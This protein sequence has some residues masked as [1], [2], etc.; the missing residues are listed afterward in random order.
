S[1]SH[2]WSRNGAHADREGIPAAMDVASFPWLVT[3]LRGFES[4]HIHR[5]A[6]L[7]ADAAH[8]R[9]FFASRD[10][11][12]LIIVP[13][14]YGNTLRGFL[15]VEQVRITKT[16]LEEDITM[17]KFLGE[18]F[19]NALERKRAE[20]EL[21]VSEELFRS[22][23]ESIPLPV[24]ITHLESGRI[25][26][27]NG[28]VTPFFGGSAGT[29]LAMSIDDLY[30]DRRDR[31]R[32][33]WELLSRGYVNNY[34]LRLKRIDGTGFDV[35]ASAKII[36]YR[37]E[38]AALSILT[39]ITERKI[40]E[41]QLRK[42]F[43]AV[44]QSPT[45]VMITDAKAVIEY[46]NPRFVQM[47]GYAVEEVLGQNPRILKSGETPPEEYGKLWETII[48]GGEWR[49][50]F[51]NRK[52]NGDLYW[53]SVSIS[54]IRSSEGVITHFL[55]V[56][57]DITEQ[58]R[59][60]EQLRHSQKLEAVGQLAGGIAHDFNNILTA[61]IG[62][63]S[64]LQ[65]IMSDDDPSRPHVDQILTL[66]DKAANLTQS[67]LAFSRKQIIFLKPIDVNEVIRRVEK[68]LSRLIGE[69]I[70]LRTLVAEDDLM[71]M[72]DSGQIEQV[73]MNL[74]T[75]S[76]DAM[77][78]GGV[79]SIET[80]RAEIN[81]EFIQHYGFGE[82]GAYAV[83]SVTDTGVGMDEKTKERIFE[84]FF[85]TKEV[86]K[87]TGLGLSIVYG[88]I[89]QHN[90]YINVDSEPGKGTTFRIYF[91]LIKS[92]VQKAGLKEETAL[93]GGTETILVAEDE[94]EV[95]KITK[96]MLERFG[97]DVI[98][99]VDGEDAVRKFKENKDTV[100]LLL[101]DVIMPKKNGKE[102][103]EEIAA[104]QPGIR[105]LFTSG[106]APDII[107]KKGILEEGINFITKPVTP[108]DLLKKVRQV[109]EA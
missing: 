59:L 1:R 76:R 3:K 58:K 102:A 90:G 94:P 2:E 65:M 63:G 36:T 66:A 45:A 97:Y 56:Q 69:D 101:F 15:G 19:V 62:Y 77:P 8:E 47:T 32:F 33:M 18:I 7:P 6:E 20:E 52:K 105:V 70:E 64:L 43:R 98:E 24:L 81:T 31:E 104:M 91:P 103:Y 13:M 10:I 17:L 88:I 106:Y 79:L 109:I 73:L 16:W 84:P 26:F 75:N 30:A 14:V 22:L 85:T 72:G 35:L 9:D 29:R 82:P 41:Q 87:G 80:A 57:E 44:E 74:V 92:D 61:I 28:L 11:Q 21:K 48:K 39:D 93:Q 95:R 99:A 100:R 55:E 25:L 60:E 68:L 23:V 89:R 49:G 71:I 54:P 78:D 34:E 51:H 108:K 86:G 4:I 107:H 5:I 42:L 96:A 53:A 40:V 67:L 27:G 83:I 37:G 38:R 46:V 12:C 50:I